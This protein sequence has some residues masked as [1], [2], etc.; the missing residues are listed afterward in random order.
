VFDFPASPTDGQKYTPAGGA[1]YIWSAA[2]TAWKIQGSIGASGNAFVGD[3]PPASPQPGQFWWESD[4]G[5]LFMWFDDGNSQQW[6]QIN[7][8]N[9]VNSLT[10][11]VETLVTASGTYTKPAGLKFLDVEG[12]GPGGGGAQT[13]TPA[14]SQWSV[15]SGAGAGAWGRRLF[16]ASELGATTPYTIGAPGTGGAV[17]TGG[18]GGTSEFG[19]G[20]NCTLGG[21]TG[22]TRSASTAAPASV[23]GGAGGAAGSGWTIGVNGEN[24]HCSVAGIASP[25]NLRGTGGMTRFSWSTNSDFYIG[26]GGPLPTSGYGCGACGQV[27]YNSTAGSSAPAGGPGMFIFR[28]YF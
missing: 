10:R 16:A 15:A 20:L 11:I 19:S 6:V 17:A 18:N 24:G 13:V 23:G 12:V 1:T 3:G 2:T 28:E 22:A 21:G 7:V 25:L 27:A 26:N 5:N 9:S 4:T 14:A 8:P